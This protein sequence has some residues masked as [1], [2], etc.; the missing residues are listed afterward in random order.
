MTTENSSL[1]S[2]G[3]SAS[4]S[5]TSSSSTDNSSSQGASTPSQSSDSSNAASTQG[6]VAASQDAN[7]NP[8]VAP[9]YQPNF[10]F[11]AFGKEHEI[12]DTFRGLIK[13]K[14][15]EEKIRK[16]HEK[17]YAMEQFQ[18]E[19]KKYKSELETFRQQ[20]DPNLKAMNHFNNLLKNKDWD[21]FFGGLKIP[22]EE[23]YNWVE[24][25][26]SLQAMPPEQRAEFERQAQVR[27]QNYAYEQELSQTQQQYQ[28]LA[29]ETRS[30]QLDNLMARGDVSKQAEA[31]DQAY[32]QIGAFR[33]LVIEEAV[34]HYHRTGEDLPADQAVQMTIQKYSRFLQTQNQGVVSTQQQVQAGASQGT[35][36]GQVPIIPHVGGSARSPIKKQPRSLDDLK[37]LAKQHQT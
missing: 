20:A 8:V 18:Q 31:V 27:Q 5:D 12:E 37:A 10:K 25:Q 1:E 21:N 9:A 16:F 11:K 32:G 3:S 15:T 36:Q 4:S 23:I 29:T 17:A 34:N 35:S 22:K 6:S 14:E 33:N 13:D 30:M 2:T 26:L 28:Q 24:K 19:S 7:G